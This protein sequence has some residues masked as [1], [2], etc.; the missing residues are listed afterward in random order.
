MDRS[1]Y[2]D[3]EEWVGSKHEDEAG[4]NTCL[5]PSASMARNKENPGHSRPMTIGIILFVTE[6]QLT[7]QRVRDQSLD[8]VSLQE[9][10]EKL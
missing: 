3:S 4:L 5:N 2:T 6:P 7:R 1:I 10:F 8:G 9:F